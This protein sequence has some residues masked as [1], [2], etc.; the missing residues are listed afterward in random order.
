MIILLLKYMPVCCSPRLD[1][2][3]EDI[4][5]DKIAEWSKTR[6]ETTCYRNSELLL[7][8]KMWDV[9]NRDKQGLR[10]EHCFVDWCRRIARIG[11]EGAAT[12]HANDESRFRKLAEDIFARDLTAEQKDDPTYWLSESKSITTKQRNLINV[13][14][15]KNLGDYRVAYYILEHGIPRLLNPENHIATLMIL[16]RQ[17]REAAHLQNMLEEFLIWHSSLLQWLTKLLKSPN[18]IMARKLSDRDQKEWQAERR[19]RKYEVKQQ[20]REGAHL[21][22]LRDTDC[23]SYDNMSATEQRVLEG[24]ECG[25]LKKI[26]DQVR[27]Q[28]PE[29]CN[30]NSRQEPLGNGVERPSGSNRK[31]SH[32]MSATEQRVFEDCQGGKSRKLYDEVRARKPEHCSGNSRQR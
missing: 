1:A 12:E 21:A 2:D 4:V 18:T 20:M 8:K 31:R 29:H 26:L 7:H 6:T 32:D 9:L 28:K 13:I 23:A 10:K 15:R 25:Q 16:R 11:A 17:P 30:S 22:E 24:F 19:R 5:F 27:V 14:M 3:C